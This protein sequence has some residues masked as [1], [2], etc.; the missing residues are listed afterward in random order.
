MAKIKRT[1]VNFKTIFF[2]LLILLLFY[3]RLINLSWGLPFP[4]HPDERNIA[5][6]V[7]QL[8]CSLGSNFNWKDCFNP[9]F[10]AYGQ[11]MIYLAYLLSWIF[12]FFNYSKLILDYSQAV[13]N[14]RLISAFASIINSFILYQIIKNLLKKE[15]LLI[16]VI[17]FLIIIFSPYAIQFSHFGTT[18]SLLMLFFSLIIYICFL[19]YDKKINQRK[20]LLLSSFFVGLAIATKVSA[21][22][23]LIMPALTI[24]ITEK[25]FFSAITKNIFW[26]FTFFV[27]TILV[28]IIF[29]PHNLISWSDF[30]ASLRYEA[31]VASGIY[32]IFYTRQFVKSIPVWFQMVKI[33]PYAV[34]PFWWLVIFYFLFFDWQSKKIILLKLAFFIYLLSF[35]FFF[36]KWTRFM[37]PIFPILTIFI[38]LLT[39]KIKSFL[40]KSLLTLLFIL[41]GIA[42]LS[43]YQN[44]DSRIQASL[45][46]YQNAPNNAYILTETANVIDIPLIISKG[47]NFQ[48]VSFDFYNLDQD[49]NLQEELKFHL[50]KADYVI[51]PSTRIINNHYCQNNVNYFLQG[52]WFDRCSNLKK[53]YPKLNHYYEE[54]I[55]GKINFRQIVKFESYPTLVIN[56]FGFKKKINFIDSKAEETWFVFD[57]PEIL[58]FKKIKNEN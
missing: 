33:F 58:V 23:F 7:K 14:L 27:L 20:F 3:S 6:S 29:S 1:K 56:L 26:L 40:L 43:V 47:K 13:I 54:L 19:Y 30:I 57:H 32:P 38:I 4:M 52:Y 39:S 15:S 22:L 5:I 18:E 28:A 25:N 21:L 41:P 2:S 16:N 46:F 53:T 24:I 37:A 51:I 55:S 45:W 11:F 17:S 9:H 48:I 31:D 42:Y 10:F 35:S 34:S 36:V 50:K 8:S 44:L 49:K 12:N